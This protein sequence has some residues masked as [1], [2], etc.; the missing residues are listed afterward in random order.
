MIRT[1]KA[2]ATFMPFVTIATIVVLGWITFGLAESNQTIG[3][4]QQLVFDSLH[5]VNSEE[6]F[7]NTS[8]ENIMKAIIKRICKQ[9]RRNN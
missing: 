5:L 2:Q 6:T 7:L 1:K 8:F 9:W 3:A 4:S